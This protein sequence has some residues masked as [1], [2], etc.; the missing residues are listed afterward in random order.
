MPATLH[1]VAKR[2]GLSIT[3]VSHVLNDV[4]GKRI[5]FETR[6]RV[7]EAALELSYRP[8]RVAQGLRLQRTHSI[9]FVSDWIGTSPF[10]GDV[11][12]GAQDAAARHG[13][14]LMLMLSGLDTELEEREIRTLRDRQVDGII[15]AAEYHR[16]VI[17]P[18]ALQGTA[19]VLLD[20]RCDDLGLSS[21]IP[22]EVAGAYAATTELLDHGHRRIGFVTDVHD[23]PA[24]KGRLAGYRKALRDRHIRFA[25]NLVCADES[26]ASGGYRAASALLEAP[27]RPT[28]LFCFNDRMAMGAYQA[29]A[30]QNLRIPHDLSI[31]GY[32][33]QVLLAASL[34][35][36]LTS[37]ELP[38]Y[39]MG[40]WAVTKLIDT[41]TRTGKAQP[42]QI[43][44]PCPIVRRGSVAVP[45]VA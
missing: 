27:G 1:D 18:A 5:A 38:H 32:D 42:E 39:K 30:D 44:M 29:A 16:N 10:A 8:N 31:V 21:V 40:E 3:T 26:T 20:A 45:E 24:S 41:I 28:A 43:T 11:I 19:T 6:Q 7:R 33:N 12:L 17:V 15:Y 25:R 23:I 13:Y 34:R 22:D 2:T 35:P 37:I 9:G 4:P 14:L 36:G